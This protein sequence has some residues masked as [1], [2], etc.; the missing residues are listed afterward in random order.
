M[1][2]RQVD[3]VVA[4]WKLGG[5][6]HRHPGERGMSVPDRHLG[7]NGQR[8]TRRLLLAANLAQD[9][10]AFRPVFDAVMSFKYGFLLVFMLGL[11]SAGN[12]RKRRN[13]FV[14]D[15]DAVA[16]VGGDVEGAVTALVKLARLNAQ[17]EQWGRLD[18]GLSTHP[19]QSRRIQ[20]ILDENDVAAAR[21]PAILAAVDRDDD[22]YPL[23][24]FPRRKSASC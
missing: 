2:K 15:R 23:P 4:C 19:D 11:M 22:R 9:Y 1:S 20:A 16:I 12:F 6:A 21:L 8:V 18:A 5:T 7:V 17:P 24:R 10:P 13:E 14:A 3:Y